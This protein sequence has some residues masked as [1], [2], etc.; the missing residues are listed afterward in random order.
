MDNLVHIEALLKNYK[1]MK[2]RL[3]YMEKLLA[4]PILETYEDTI[5]ELNFKK[6]QW[7][8]QGRGP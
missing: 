6:E 3:A 8:Y 5:E 2:Q 4:S 7:L 1:S